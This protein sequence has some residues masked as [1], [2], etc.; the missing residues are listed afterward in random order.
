MTTVQYRLPLARVSLVTAVLVVAGCSSAPP[1]ESASQSTFTPL[2]VGIYMDPLAPKDESVTKQLGPELNRALEAN[3]QGDITPA[4]PVTKN[5]DGAEYQSMQR[6]FFDQVG[7]DNPTLI[8]LIPVGCRIDY[9]TV[10]DDNHYALK[11]VTLPAEPEP[12]VLAASEV[13]VVNGGAQPADAAMKGGDAIGAKRII[14]NKAAKVVQA[15]VVFD[16][17]GKDVER[18]LAL[19]VFDTY[20]WNP[21]DDRSKPEKSAP[22]VA[23][24]KAEGPDYLKSFELRWRYDDSP[25]FL[26]KAKTYTGDLS[27]ALADWSNAVVKLGGSGQ[28]APSMEDPRSTIWRTYSQKGGSE[29]QV[30]TGTADSKYE[31]R[32]ASAEALAGAF[33]AT[34]E[35]LRDA[36]KG[37][38]RLQFKSK[39]EETGVA[40]DI[41]ALPADEQP[42]VVGK[43]VR[44]KE[45]RGTRAY[46]IETN[47]SQETI[48]DHEKIVTIRGTPKST[49]TGN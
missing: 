49:G 37:G 1:A 25:F 8:A 18:K 33:K 12:I 39:D 46:L 16:N 7:Q 38:I 34:F 6:E 2:R 3:K 35:K 30:H 29:W 21:G 27:K 26:F 9:T 4:V 36:D 48:W 42:V 22:G 23:V 11:S 31:M 10:V 40:S 28:V 14:Y 32:F 20:S 45:K 24:W 41:K 17:G 13:T 44:Y 19:S 15:T 43:D 47:G 5:S